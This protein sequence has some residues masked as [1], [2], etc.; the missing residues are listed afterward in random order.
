MLGW[1]LH[2]VAVLGFAHAALDFGAQL[3]SAAI[4]QSTE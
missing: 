1:R 3:A 2:L 4:E